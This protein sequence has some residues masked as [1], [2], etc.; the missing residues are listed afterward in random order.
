MINIEDLEK[1]LNKHKYSLDKKRTETIYQII[2]NDQ[3]NSVGWI[4]FRLLECSSELVVS[5]GREVDYYLEGMKIPISEIENGV[6]FRKF[7]DE[8][9][10]QYKENIQKEEVV[11]KLTE[12]KKKVLSLA[13]RCRKL[14]PDL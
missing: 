8:E 7:L 9:K 13:S 3:G 4:R 6:R 10:I 14:I 2:R 12:Y 1:R 11:K 5:Y